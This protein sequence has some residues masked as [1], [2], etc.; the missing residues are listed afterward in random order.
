VQSNLR[1]IAAMP[2]A[3][4]MVL[5]VASQATAWTSS[6]ATFYVRSTPNGAPT[7]AVLNP[8]TRNVTIACQ[9]LDATVSAAG[10]GSSPVW[11]YVTSPVRGWVS[12]L[13]IVETNYARLTPSIPACANK[14][15]DPT[16]QVPVSTNAT[17]AGAAA[18]RW[19]VA[20]E[21]AVVP[22]ESEKAGNPM[23]SWSGW[24]YVF[25]FDAY[26]IGAGTMMPRGSA[27]QVAEV[28]RSQGRLNSGTNGPPGA[29]YFWGATANNAAGHVAV[30]VGNGT[31]IGTLGWIGERR[32]IQRYNLNIAP[33]Y[34]GYVV[35]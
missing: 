13:A 14:S 34:L 8:S 26:T 28:F 15:P 23:S 2:L 20:H 17:A 19:A 12:D 16:A 30:A 7:G 4:A 25:A 11:N 6:P 1:K 24:C 9:V 35:L 31:A 3:A 10:L 33:N 29:L 18:L 27:A 32:P 22:A 21:G 5:S